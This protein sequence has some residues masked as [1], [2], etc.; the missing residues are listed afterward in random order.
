MFTGTC[1]RNTVKSPHALF[2]KG[3]SPNAL[4]SKQNC[5]EYKTCPNDTLVRT[6]LLRKQKSPNVA[7]NF[8][9]LV[10]PNSVADLNPVRSGPFWSDPE[11][12]D[13]IRTL[14]LINALKSTF[15]V[16]VKAIKTLQ[17][18]VAYIFN[19]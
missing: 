14:V 13:W 18:S 7:N 2:P 11:L 5:S 17:I 6:F 1:I 9:I 15:F 10:V 4:F 3:L 19:S 8:Y 16:C 12:W